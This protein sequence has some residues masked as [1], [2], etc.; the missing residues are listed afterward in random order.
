MPSRI[1]VVDD[2]P[3]TAEMFRRWLN[4]SATEIRTARDGL[5]AVNAAEEFRPNLILLDL[6]LP[7]LSGFEVVERVRQQPWGKDIIVIGMSGLPD[8]YDPE[9]AGTAGFD[10][11]LLKPVDYARLV[12]LVRSL[13]PPKDC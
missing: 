12:E 7:T 11:F 5:E 1:L 4:R 9:R 8:P 3:N 10:A 2:Y 13:F 6:D